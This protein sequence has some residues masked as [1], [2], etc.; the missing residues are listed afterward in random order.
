M[1]LA[2][3]RV[4][5]KMNGF[6]VIASQEAKARLVER[7]ALKEISVQDVAEWLKKHTRRL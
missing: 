2:C 3:L 6:Q 5:L 4:M 1:A 7:I